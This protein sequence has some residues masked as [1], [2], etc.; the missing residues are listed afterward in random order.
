MVFFIYMQR[1]GAKISPW[2]KQKAQPG[3]S[4]LTVISSLAEL[5][6]YKFVCECFGKF[7]IF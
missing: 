6:W 3:E 2:S 4:I 5:R 1:A 7:K